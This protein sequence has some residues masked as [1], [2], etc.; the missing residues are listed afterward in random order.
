MFRKCMAAVGIEGMKNIHKE[1]LLV[2]ANF[3][4]QDKSI[5]IAAIGDDGLYERVKHK[6]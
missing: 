1:G 5:L 4:E 2:R 6:L 3:Q